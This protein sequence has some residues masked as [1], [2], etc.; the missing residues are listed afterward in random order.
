MCYPRRGEESSPVC[1]YVA[2]K[3]FKRQRSQS[4][5]QP[6][7]IN[8]QYSHQH[9]EERTNKRTEKREKLTNTTTAG[10]KN[11]NSS[12][13]AEIPLQRP[14]RLNK[15]KLVASVGQRTATTKSFSSL[16]RGYFQVYFPGQ[17]DAFRQDDG[18]IHG[19]IE[20]PSKRSP[21]FCIMKEK[22]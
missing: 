17:T 21:H 8:D 15:L 13:A 18:P 7:L 11:V 5:T 20:P 1:A 12:S 14:D 3:A 6:V 19:N 22:K 16:P 4:I 2:C 9:N 10:E